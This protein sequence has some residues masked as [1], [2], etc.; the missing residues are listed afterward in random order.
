MLFKPVKEN[1]EKLPT[2]KILKIESHV[3]Y[4]KWAYTGEVI[5]ESFIWNY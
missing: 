5:F 1:S 3:L 2:D 4:M